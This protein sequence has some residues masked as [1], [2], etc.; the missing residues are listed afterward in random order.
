MKLIATS[1]FRNCFDESVQ[2]P[3]ALHEDHVHKGCIF[4]IG[5]EAKLEALSADNKRLLAMLNEAGRIADGTDPKVVKAIQD[6][7]K[8]EK[9]AQAK[10]AAKVEVAG[11]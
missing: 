3:D 9:A 5:G 4:N 10:L 6:E 1:D 11:K 2:I 8:A 7:A